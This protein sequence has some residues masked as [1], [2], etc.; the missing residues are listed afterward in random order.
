M[1]RKSFVSF[2][3]FFFSFCFGCTLYYAQDKKR[4]DTLALQK[5]I[6][7]VVITG[8]KKLIDRK[9][10]RLIFNV[11]NSIASQGVDATEA[12]ANTPLLKVDENRGISIVGKSGVSVM[13]NDRMIN[14]SGNEL[15]NYLRSLRSDN[16]SKIEVITTPPS[17]YE[18]QGNSGLINIILKKNPNFGFSGNFSTSLTQR[19]WFN[20]SSNLTLNYQDEKLSASTKLR[21]YDNM[22]RVYENN[23]V[24]GV[25]SVE[26]QDERKD[27]NNGLG[28]NLSVDYKLNKTS[29]IGAIYDIGIGNSNMNINNISLYKTNNSVTN[30]LQIYTE[31]RGNRNTQTLN[32]YYDLNLDGNAKKMS[33]TGNYY[34]YTP[35]T[36]V[37]FYTY[38]KFNNTYSAV[39][40]TSSTD[41]NIYSGQIDFTLPYKFINIETGIKF[42][43]YNNYSNVEFFNLVNKNYEIDLSKGNIFNYNEKNYAIYFSGSKDFNEKLS[44]KVGLRYEYSQLDAYSITTMERRKHDYGKVFPSAYITYKPNKNNVFSINYSKR[45]SRPG[46]RALNPFRWYTGPYKYFTGNP[47]LQPS[48]NHNF[49][50]GYIWKGKISFTLAYQRMLNS[51]DQI[52]SFV[53]NILV[54]TYKNY[55][56]T[57]YYGVDVSYSDNLLKWWQTTINLSTSY[58]KSE[59]FNTNALGQ[60]GYSLFYSTQ[61]TFNLNNS[62]TISFILNYWQSIPSKSGNFY[63]NGQGNLSMGFR[64]MFMGKNLQVSLTASDILRQQLSSGEAYFSDN[65][66]YFNN[67][68]DFRSVRLSASYKF[69]NSKVKGNRKNFQFEETNR[70]N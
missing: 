2:S 41:Y 48:Y 70:A 24:F 67:Y 61:N 33:V 58:S 32:A 35:K 28:A 11:E 50:I 57:D 31:N 29:N 64:L 43:N 26:S 6:E 16:I 66:Q 36:F 27:F 30:D 52:A 39:K 51:Y 68:Y 55:F 46:I 18:A 4:I 17:K 60:N 1:I 5:E 47:L 54:S 37:D 20:G 65:T 15:I 62:K 53:D 42:T 10:D 12:L 23:N 63:N 49:E 13:V 56:N 40:N 22:S 38:D 9:V 8:K 25:N 34:S 44:S 7:T 59:V 19:T 45:I 69:G 14:L 3:Q 21:H